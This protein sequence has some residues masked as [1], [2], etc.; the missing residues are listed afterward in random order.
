LAGLYHAAVY[1]YQKG[2]E[3]PIIIEG[4]KQVWF[5]LKIATLHHSIIH[6]LAGITQKITLFHLCTI[7]NH[8]LLSL[9][10]DELI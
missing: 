3:F 2:L 7:F 1:Y 8:F 9:L 10:L 4:D 6:M 5:C